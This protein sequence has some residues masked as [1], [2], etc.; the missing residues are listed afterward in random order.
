MLKVEKKSRLVVVFYSPWLQR[1]Q[2]ICAIPMEGK[3][4]KLILI[5]LFK[6]TVDLSRRGNR[7]G[8]VY[9]FGRAFARK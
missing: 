5:R 1:E 6:M 3:T 2:L 8:S 7:R 4:G 9:D